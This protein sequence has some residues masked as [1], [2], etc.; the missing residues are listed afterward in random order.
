MI[1]LLFSFQCA[2]LA[3]LHASWILHFYFR[4]PQ[5]LMVPQTQNCRI[6]DF[7]FN[8]SEILLMK[9]AL[10]WCY[11]LHPNKLKP[12]DNF[13]LRVQEANKIYGGSIPYT[14][15]RLNH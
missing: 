8:R 9:P 3:K 6:L 12:K 1:V 15:S 13:L 14:S 4:A 10:S 7:F 5:F 11:S 2:I